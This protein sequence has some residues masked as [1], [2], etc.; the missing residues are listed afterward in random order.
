MSA[1][2]SDNSGPRISGID[3]GGLAQPATTL[4]EKISDPLGGIFRPYQIVRVAKAEV[5]AMRLK[6]EGQ[7]EITDLERRAFHRFLKE[8]ARNQKN[9]E[10]I[11]RKALP[12]L[13]D[14]ADPAR[15][16]DDWITN[17]FEK[18]RIVSDAEMQRLWA[19]ILAGEANKPGSFAPYTLR[20][21]KDLTQADAKLF[22]RLARFVWRPW[23]D[24]RAFIIENEAM[25]IH[26]DPEGT[27]RHPCLFMVG[28]LSHLSDLGLLCTSE[29]LLHR[30][31]AVAERFNYFNRS[32]IF[33]S[34]DGKPIES[35]YPRELSEFVTGRRYLTVAGHELSRIVE[36]T[37]VAVY[38]NAA[39]AEEGRTLNLSCE[40]V[41]P[42]SVPPQPLQQQ[43]GGLGAGQ[44]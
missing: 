22:A 41:V 26:W 7:I 43:N 37:P 28:H 39:I 23:A 20:V 18:S 32:F 19:N 42:N 16:E 5:E 34:P 25:K 44:R 11:T 9:I 35:T 4:I 38:A 40:E 8:E 10:A 27:G 15:I 17:F 29:M 2:S 14:T 36:G 6:T 24:G 12:E 31:Q 13:E 21:V 30:A 3:V 1:D 33:K